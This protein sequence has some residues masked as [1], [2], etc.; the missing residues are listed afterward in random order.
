MTPDKDATAIVLA[1]GLSSRMGASKLSLEWGQSTVI[2]SVCSTIRSA[3]IE[4]IIVVLGGYSDE[5][6][7]ALSGLTDT[8]KIKR[9]HNPDSANSGMLDS[10]KLGLKAI[11]DN[12]EKVLI[13]LGDNPQVTPKTINDLLKSS[14][15]KPIIIPS[16]KMRRGH[17]WIISSQMI[18]EILSTPPGM[19]MRN[20]INDRSELIAYI[21]GG[22]EILM[23]LD[24]PQDYERQKP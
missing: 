14:D 11:S 22:P 2:G 5:V 6:D 8:S 9:V 18:P 24:T 12:H 7:Q 20:W 3:G 1:A 10:L 4:D 19:T 13:A 16:F 15:L 17:P 21:E 23:D